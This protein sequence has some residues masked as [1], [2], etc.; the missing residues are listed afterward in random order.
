MNEQGYKFNTLA[1]HFPQKIKELAESKNIT[2]GNL[3][4]LIHAGVYYID[5]ACKLIE[6][7]TIKAWHDFGVVMKEMLP[8]PQ[9]VEDT[10]FGIEKPPSKEPIGTAGE[11]LKIGDCIVFGKDGKIYKAKRG[12]Q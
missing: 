10:F 9:Q 2:V 8:N 4:G 3:R 7:P 6:N 12:E 11:D 1:E 5:D